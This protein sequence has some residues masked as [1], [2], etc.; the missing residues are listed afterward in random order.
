MVKINLKHQKEVYE[1]WIDGNVSILKTKNV[2]LHININDNKK[3]IIITFLIINTGDYSD[4]LLVL[5]DNTTTDITKQILTSENKI[6]T[7][8][9]F[10]IDNTKI[11]NNLIVIM[12]I[13]KYNMNMNKTTIT[14]TI[15]T[16][17]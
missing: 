5:I 7:N 6:I 17:N 16:Q 11:A 8:N 15:M 9:I 13:N 14:I 12:I 1:K 2:I 10:A 4:S 3:D